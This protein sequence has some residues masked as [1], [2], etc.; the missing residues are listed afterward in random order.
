[1]PYVRLISCAFVAYLLGFA[2]YGEAKSCVYIPTSPTELGARV[3]GAEWRAP[4]AGWADESPSLLP[5]VS[6]EIPADQLFSPDRG[7]YVPGNPYL[8]VGYGANRW[9]K[10]N[11]NY[12]TKLEA[13]GRFTLTERGA[14]EPAYSTL[15][16]FEPNGGGT[17]ALP[18]KSL[19][20]TLDKHAP[21]RGAFF[22]GQG[23]KSYRSFLLRNDGNDWY[24][25]LSGGISTM[26]RDAVLHLIVSS[27]DIGGQAYRPV[28]V[29]LNGTYWGIHNLREAINKHYF[30]TR[31]GVSAKNV[32]ILEHEESAKDGSRVTIKV[33]SGDKKSAKEYLEMLRR[34]SVLDMTKDA[35]LAE[36]AREVD[37]DNYT[38]YVITEAF[39]ANADW[40]YNNLQLWRAHKKDTV[41]GKYGDGRWRWVLYDLDMAGLEVHK[42]GGYDFDMFAYLKSGAE[43]GVEHPAYLI[44]LLWRNSGYRARFVA[45]TKELVATVF[46]REATSAVIEA[47]KKVV[48]PEIERHFRRWGRSWTAADWARAVDQAIVTFLEKRRAATLAHLEK[49]F[50]EDFN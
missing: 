14:K 42:K 21:Y 10:S 13:T 45:R 24:G 30:E 26:M 40:P 48:A 43:A 8:R 31:Y 2:A 4:L 6:L 39:Y 15:A 17:R 34:F 23:V 7:I 37:L 29:R 44:N 38:D 9:G 47:A 50:K 12:Y 28:S 16:T 35:S 18:Q 36:I 3:P 33:D 1:M 22:P 11:A 19:K 46:S 20:V 25:P 5:I 32:D 49:H 41:A 27:L